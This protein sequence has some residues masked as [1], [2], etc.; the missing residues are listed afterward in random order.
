MTDIAVYL[1]SNAP[2]NMEE[3]YYDQYYSRAL[4][5][6]TKP[7]VFFIRSLRFLES[8]LLQAIDSIIYARMRILCLLNGVESGGKR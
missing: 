5:N 2:L 7:S 1:N 6:L 8:L 3:D 4:I